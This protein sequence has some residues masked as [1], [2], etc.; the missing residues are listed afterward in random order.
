MWNVLIIYYN[1]LCASDVGFS[2]LFHWS[3]DL[4]SSA[5]LFLLDTILLSGKE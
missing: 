4:I 5:A 2:I 3:V 1:F